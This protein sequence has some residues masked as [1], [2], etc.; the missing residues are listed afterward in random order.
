MKKIEQLF[1]RALTVAI[2]VFSSTQ[3][4]AQ[5]ELLVP[6]DANFYDIIIG[7][8]ID[9]GAR[10]D[11]LAVYVLK[12]GDV[13]RVDRTMN[14]NFNLNLIG[15]DGDDATSM[16]AVLIPMK[17]E[18]SQ[19]YPWSYINI[20]GDNLTTTI[21]NIIF[22]GI[23]SDYEHKVT[24]NIA[25]VAILETGDYGRLLLDR[26]VITGFKNAGVNDSSKGGYAKVTNC[27]FRNIG[28]A[29]DQWG[30]TAFGHWDNLGLLDSLIFQNNTFFNVGCRV[31][32][33][34]DNDLHNYVLIEHNTFFGSTTG[35]SS[36]G[37]E[38]NVN[39]I[40]RNNIFVGTHGQGLMK[41]EEALWGQKTPEG[42][43]LGGP[44]LISIDTVRGV[45]AILMR[46]SLGLT[47]A[48]R[49]I[50]LQNNLNWWPEKLVEAW[51]TLDK[52]GGAVIEPKYMTIRS[53][54]MIA[55]IPGM[56][57]T[58]GITD[59]DP[60]FDA[61]TE[62][63]LVDIIVDWVWN[64][65]RTTDWAGYFRLFDKEENMFR[66]EWPLPENLAYTNAALATAS[67]EG[68]H[69]GDL[70]WFPEDKAIW[71]AIPS[72][73][74]SNTVIEIELSCYPNPFT[75][76]TNISYTLTKSENVSLTVYDALGKRV[77]VLVDQFQS[78][79]DYIVG[80]D[81]SSI[82]SGVYF[83]KL[84]SASFSSTKQMVLAK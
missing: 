54:Q 30:G 58:G 77:N 11:P 67:T 75:D 46:D 53:E 19:S 65:R 82:S 70:N 52:D 49:V 3:L 25:T 66:L 56:T 72:G 5:H 8:T 4:F 76:A 14:I 9:N 48:D 44:A 36:P 79:G 50:T 39:S 13:Y 35:F 74:K 81:G 23:P 63:G 21:E 57:L 10:R 59:V 40:V 78:V 61:A 83:L 84:E 38:N 1:R 18:V 24:G 55:Q 73:I 20:I 12:R 43:L 28:E 7:D 22:Q 27:T 60:G 42:E 69:L 41:S 51:K 17:N 26:V 15:E 32:T 2:I 68:L 45:T 16:P 6:A 71:E 80:F 47:E 31:I 37:M 29:K 34:G 62:D 33:A 64:K